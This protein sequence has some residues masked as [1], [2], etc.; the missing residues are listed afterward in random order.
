MGT[1]R[2]EAFVGQLLKWFAWPSPSVRLHSQTGLHL[3]EDADDAERTH[4]PIS[5][6][7]LL[8]KTRSN[9]MNVGRQHEDGMRCSL[10]SL[11]I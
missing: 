3:S 10:L 6:V 1:W 2:P 4:L 7:V 8:K 9:K 5:R 11:K